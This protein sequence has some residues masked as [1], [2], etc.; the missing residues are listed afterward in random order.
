M[1]E[2]KLKPGKETILICLGT[3]N[4]VL[5]AGGLFFLAGENRSLL[6]QVQELQVKVS[7]MEGSVTDTVR[8][9]SSEIQRGQERADSF[10]D[11]FQVTVTSKDSLRAEVHVTADLKEYREGEDV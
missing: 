5:A 11:Q 9:I 4:L 7:Q 1:K 8:G 3:A 10:V 6:R 2:R